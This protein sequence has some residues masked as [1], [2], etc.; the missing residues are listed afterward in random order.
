ME[1]KEKAQELM[2]EFKH[3]IYPFAAGKGYLTK[4]VDYEVMKNNSRHCACIAVDEILGHLK[5][6]ATHEYHMG[7]S[8]AYWN[9]VREEL[10]KL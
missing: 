1:A 4:D 2:N 10:K 7:K 5:E 3:W 9:D 8:I 6:I